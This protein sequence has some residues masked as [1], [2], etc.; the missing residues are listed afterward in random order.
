M[1]WPFSRRVTAARIESGPDEPLERVAPPRPSEHALLLTELGAEPAGWAAE[2]L[3]ILLHDIGAGHTFEPV[4]A[5]DAWL[6]DPVTFCLVYTAPFSRPGD[7]LTGIRCRR[8]DLDPHLPLYRGD[9]VAGLEMPDDPGEYAATI[10]ESIGEPLGRMHDLLRVDDRGIGWWG[11][12]D[13][14]L[15]S[16]P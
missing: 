12:L 4:A 5:V 16:R 1:R 3:G 9:D 11:T 15:P 8:G 7:R 2:V 13:D 10:T 6:E 14:T